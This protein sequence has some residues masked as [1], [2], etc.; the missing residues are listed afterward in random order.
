METQRFGFLVISNAEEISLR[1]EAIAGEAVLSKRTLTASVPVSLL[2]GIVS[3]LN[4][5]V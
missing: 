3:S 4:R 5:C 2:D 1:E